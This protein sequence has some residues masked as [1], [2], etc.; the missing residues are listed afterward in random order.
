MQEL[1]RKKTVF[2]DFFF[3]KFRRKNLQN[4][5]LP[6][7]NENT[8]EFGVLWVLNTYTTEGI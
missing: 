6:S 7:Q 2:A 3:K 5:P 1:T 8:T 4:V